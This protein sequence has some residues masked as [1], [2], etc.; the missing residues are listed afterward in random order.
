MYLIKKIS[1]CLFFISFS[2]TIFG[3]ETLTQA[4]YFWDTDPGESNGI[5]FSAADGNYNTN[6]ENIFESAIGVPATTG[7][8]TFN[9][10]VQDSNGNWGLIHTQVIEVSTA[11]LGANGIAVLS[12]AEYFWDTDPG[13]GN[14]I[15]FSAADGDY[16][17]NLENILE[18]AIGV[19]TTTG[20]HTFNTRAQDSNGNWGP[21]NTQII[22]VSTALLGENAIA[23][24][25][26]AEYF[27]DTDRGEGNGIVFPAED[28]T[29][30]TVLENI[31]EGN[32]PI[33]GPMGVHTFNVRVQDSKGVWGSI[34]TQ[35]IDIESVLSV[36]ENANPDIQLKLF[37]NPSSHYFSLKSNENL[38]IENIEI[39]NLLGKQVLNK[40]LGGVSS[41]NEI[42]VDIS[43]L[44]VSSYIVKIKT[45][46][47]TSN[48]VMIKEN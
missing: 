17:T 11:L 19:P 27:W 30:N 7:L 32:V 44:A 13:E 40:D 37:P 12:N 6:L 29:F 26:N 8:H 14:G 45:N 5:V 10:R 47:G 20:L 15:V 31:L 43:N 28:G 24:I 4:E 9:I 21:V 34:N 33:V 42:K 41:Q 1:F 36:T 18:N 39:F 38:S 16:N 22:E 23:I 25:S 35:V 46:K 48:K 2:F 3:Q